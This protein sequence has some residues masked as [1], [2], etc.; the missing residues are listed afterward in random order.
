MGESQAGIKIA[1]RN[2]NNLRYSDDTTLITES[3]EE[4][5]KLLM[6]VQEESE[7]AG[8]KLNIPKTKMMASGPTISWQICGEKVEIVKDFIFLGSKITADSNRSHEI[9]KHLLLGKKS[10]KPRQHSKMQRYHFTDKGLYSQ[11]YV[12]YH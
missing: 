3:A 12:F 4:L 1:W 9:K 8:L 5:K 11:S 6:K 7:K 2:T 10:G